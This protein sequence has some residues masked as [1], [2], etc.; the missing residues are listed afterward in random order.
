MDNT[1]QNSPRMTAEEYFKAAPETNQPTELLDGEIVCLASPTRRHQNI[2][3]GVFAELR[4]YIKANGGR[5]EPYVSPMDVRLD[6]HNVVQ[7]DVFVICDPDKM[8]EH[9]LDG[10]PDFVAE[11]VSTNRSDDFDRKLWLYRRSG[12]REYWIIDPFH[13]KTV[14]YFF[15]NGSL[16]NIYTFDTPI[17]VRIW[18]GKLEIRIADFL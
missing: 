2:T 6:G 7:P 11:V 3:G 8:T 10:A 18:D 1:A 16:P 5:C 17:P 15:E 13:E 12:V 14:V 9:F 4:Q